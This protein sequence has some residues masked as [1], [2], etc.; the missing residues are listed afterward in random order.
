[1][2]DTITTP[3]PV[4]VSR[5]RRPRAA[6]IAM[7]ALVVALAAAVAIPIWYAMASSA[8]AEVQA[9]PGTAMVCNGKAVPYRSTGAD[10]GE[11]HSTFVIPIE[12]GM[13]CR[14]TV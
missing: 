2:T 12:K 14:F 6:V 7:T 10:G 13:S 5:G 9:L 4:K 1:M 11:P 8:T 3:D